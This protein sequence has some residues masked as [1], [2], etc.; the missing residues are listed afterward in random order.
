VTTV[1]RDDAGGEELILGFLAEAG[2]E[3][4][5][6]E[7]LRNKLG[8]SSASVFRSIESL[9]DKGY[10]VETS[11]R[12]YRLVE[13][14]DRLTELEIGPLLST[15]DFGR[16]ILHL[17]RCTSTSDVATQLAEEGALHG[18]VVIAESQTA[19]RGR[20]G[21]AWVSPPG[22]NLYLSVIL[23]PEF[24]PHR[25]PELTF[26]AAVAVAETLG[27]ANV[28]ARVKWPNDLEI[29]G[30]KVAGILTELQA[31]PDQVRSVVVGI[32][33]NLNVGEEDLPAELRPI[34][35]SA[36]IVRGS[37]VPR[38]LFTAALLTRLEEWYDRHAEDGFEV[39]T[40]RW[41]ELTSTLG[42]AVRVRLGDR[43]I[44]GIAQDIDETGA[45]LVANGS[46]VER[47]VA[48]DVELLRRD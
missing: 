36:R 8:L 19:G 23:R 11:P 22:K 17:D 7:T 3:F 14:P 16:T 43:E 37:P 32:G 46:E 41:R 15:H 2:D 39:I 48:G 20:R 9:R 10:R 47:V 13:I 31:G 5:S 28:P 1:D 25:A 33:V 44:R 18:E 26:V 24:P 40:A 45:L 29:D 6:G 34:A 35:T 27:E 21:R 4:T 30:R 38:A 12:G 42:E